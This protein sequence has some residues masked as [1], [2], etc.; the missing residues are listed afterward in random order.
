MKAAITSAETG[1]L[2]LYDNEQQTEVLTPVV[3]TTVEFQKDD[4]TVYFTQTYACKPEDFPADNYQSQA[5]AMQADLDR[6]AIQQVVD[7]QMQ[8][9]N[10]KVEEIQALINNQSTNEQTTA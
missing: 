1:L 2:P 4:G 10:A 9:A 3:I 5:D 7:Q 8:Q 6:T